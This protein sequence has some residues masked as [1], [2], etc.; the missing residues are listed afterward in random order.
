MSRSWI[1]KRISSSA[2]GKIFPRSKLKTPYTGILMFRRWPSFRYR[3]RNGARFRRLLSYPNRVAAHRKRISLHLPRNTWPVSRRPNMWNSVSCQK[4]PRVKYR[5]SNSGKKSGRGESGS[6]EKHQRRAE[7]CPGSRHIDIT[8]SA[9]LWA[10][11]A[12]LGLLSSGSVEPLTGPDFQEHEAAI[13]SRRN[14]G[15]PLP[16]IACCGRCDK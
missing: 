10:F 12:K 4:P 2:A 11:S 16:E 8:L 14:R 15:A 13:G 7:K 9:I 6:I 5:S 1:E 3:T